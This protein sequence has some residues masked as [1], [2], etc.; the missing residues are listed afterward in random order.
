MPTSA[1]KRNASQFPRMFYCRHMQPGICGYETDTVLVDTD[2]LKR[3]LPTG[4]G[5]PVYIHHQDV[6]LDKLKETAAG[7]VTEAFYNELDGWGWFKFLAIDD[8][9]YQAVA[10]GWSVSTAY[11]PTKW[12]AHGTKNNCPYDK[13]VLDAEFTHLAIVPDPRYEGARIF[14]PD[15]FKAYQEGK[16]RQLEELQN[17]KTKG[18]P[19]FKMF[20]NTRQ[21]VSTVDEDTQ[22][23]LQNGK[24]VSVAEMINAMKAEKEKENSDQM[25]DVMGEKM[26]LKEL[27]NKYEKMCAKKNEAD[28]KEEDEEKKEKKNKKAK[29]NEGDS[30]E[31]EDADD[32]RE[33]K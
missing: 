30:E 19:M 14:T 12:G 23:E 7:Y 31:D 15:E 17:S 24:T 11:I 10:N 21:E 18:K 25:V 16:K 33:K 28:D 26:P 9:C 3:M 6:D 20:K 1:E 4:V 13:E 32:G 8:E 2:V 22:I 27:V 5:K 29:M